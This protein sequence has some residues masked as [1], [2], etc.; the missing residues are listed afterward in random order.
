MLKT[1]YDEVCVCVCC[2]ILSLV[3]HITPSQD[4]SAAKFRTTLMDVKH[5]VCGRFGV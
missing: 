4:G 1:V 2:I 3:K 5:I